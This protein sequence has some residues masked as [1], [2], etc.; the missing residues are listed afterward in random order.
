MLYALV[1]ATES[2]GNIPLG[3]GIFLLLFSAMTVAPL[4]FAGR[5]L[6]NWVCAAEHRKN[7]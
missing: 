2:I 1:A 4:D 3:L 7:F 6:D 5:P